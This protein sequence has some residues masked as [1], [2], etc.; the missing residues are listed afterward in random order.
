MKD[1]PY[2]VTVLRKPPVDD[3]VGLPVQDMQKTF[4]DREDADR[5]Y[6][7]EVKRANRC[8]SILKVWLQRWDEQ[9]KL[10]S[11]FRSMEK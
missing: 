3:P 9:N 5:R 10:W 7:K 4:A 8:A 6:L 11:I 2:R 1:K